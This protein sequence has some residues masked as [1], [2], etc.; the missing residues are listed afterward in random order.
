M[1]FF[2]ADIPFFRILP[3]RASLKTGILPNK[4]SPAGRRVPPRQESE[5]ANRQI[6][7]MESRRVTPG[8]GD[9][10]SQPAGQ[11]RAAIGSPQ[12]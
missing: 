11:A 8:R 2:C 6:R 3:A 10:R 9:H 4:T 1:R 12:A 7:R 5:T